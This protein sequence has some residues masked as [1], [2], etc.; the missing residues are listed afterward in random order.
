MTDA[1]TVFDSGAV[2]AHRE[3]A[4]GLDPAGRFLRREIQARLV[5]RLGEVR[6]RFD[7]VL[8]LGSGDGELPDLLGGAPD[9]LVSMDSAF[10][11]ARH[12]R[13]AVVG[14]AELLPFADGAFDLVVATL[15]LHWVNDLPGAFVQLRRILRPD[16]LLLAALLGGETL[17]E[18]RESL[19]LAELEVTGG[20]AGRVSPFADL[21][22]LAGLLQRAGLALPVADS[23]R[24]TLTYPNAFALMAELRALGETSALLDRPRGFTRRRVFLRAAEVYRERFGDAEGRIPATFE[25]INLT[26]W[27]PA[28]SQP[29]PLRPGSGRIRLADVLGDEG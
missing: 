9:L 12:G 3:R 18:L 8:D 4:A 21:R 20:A 5:E 11:F 16:G 26:A 25:V 14:D 19:T 29:K 1:I 23:D 2:R 15:G 6:R 10:G 17:A 27:A 7:R 28:A 22:D 13:L 24:L